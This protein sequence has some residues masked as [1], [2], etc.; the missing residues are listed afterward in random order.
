MIVQGAH[1]V[2]TG[3]APSFTAPRSMTRD[4]FLIER[5]DPAPRSTRSSSLVAERLPGHYGVDPLADIQVFAPVYRGALGI[6][7]INT[8]L[9]DALNPAAG[10]SSAAGCGSATSSCSPAATSTTSG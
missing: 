10:R 6:D 5:A 1:A 7:A 4:L 3:E 2:R 9:R 8:R